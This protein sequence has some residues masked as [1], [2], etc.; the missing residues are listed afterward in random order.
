MGI[1]IRVL[2][3]EDPKDDAA[4]L[5]LLLRQAGYEVESERVESASSLEQ[6]LTKK[7]DIVISD[8]TMPNLSGSEAL[9]IVRAQNVEMPFIFVSG[10]IGEEAAVEAM[11]VGAQD[12]VMK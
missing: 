5:L 10:P 3:V 11:R 8:H 2:M 1:P 6:A 12:Y 7:W 4:L 9:K